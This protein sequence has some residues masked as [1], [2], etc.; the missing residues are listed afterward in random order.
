VGVD[1]EQ[2]VAAAA[3]RSVAAG[4]EGDPPRGRHLVEPARD[5]TRPRCT[6]SRPRSLAGMDAWFRIPLSSLVADAALKPKRT[7]P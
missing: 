5:P 7:K 4:V 3:D 6:S 1:A 2:E